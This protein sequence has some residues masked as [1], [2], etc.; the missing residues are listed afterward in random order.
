MN[1]KDKG[2][3]IAELHCRYFP[4]MFPRFREF[5]LNRKNFFK[6]YIEVDNIALIDVNSMSLLWYTD[7]VLCLKES[8]AAAGG[9]LL[10]KVFFKTSQ[11]QQQSICAGASIS[12]KLHLHQIETP[13]QVRYCKFCEIL[14]IAK[15][16][17]AYEQLLLKSE[18]FVGDSFVKLQVLTINRT[19]KCFPMKELDNVFS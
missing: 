10:K 15:F 13:V 3:T 7:I 19:D 14:N 4:W 11:T 6:V 2:L 8:E 5:V 12:I 9:V 16:I 18:I 17:N 1:H